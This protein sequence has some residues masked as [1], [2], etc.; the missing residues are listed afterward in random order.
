MNFMLR[1]SGFIFSAGKNDFFHTKFSLIIES[2]HHQG[3][4]R[5]TRSSSPTIQLPIFSLNHVPQYN[6]EMFL[7]HL[8][9]WW[10]HYLPGQAIP[11]LFLVTWEVNPHI[12]TTS[13]QTVVESNK[14]SPKPPPDW[15]IPAPSAAPHKVCTSDPSQLCCPSLDTLQGLNVFLV[16]R[17]PKLNTVLKV[18][19]QHCQVQRD[20]HFPAPADNTI[21][22]TS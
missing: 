19:P 10:L 9:Q 14:V 13:F 4:K 18:Q 8:Q 11:A 2:Q 12:T 16:V 20:D 17:S 1:F 21:S 5:P 22:G 6:F 7:E 3:W 15:T